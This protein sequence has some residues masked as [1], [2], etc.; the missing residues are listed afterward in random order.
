MRHPWCTVTALLAALAAPL[1]AGDPLPPALQGVEFAPVLNEQLPL[2]VPFHDESG[3]RVTLRDCCGGGKPVLLVLIQYRCPM[4][5]NLALNGLTESLRKLADER[6]FRLGEHFTVVG[7]SFDDRETPDVAAGKKASYL[8]AYGAPEAADAWRFL[9]G[10]KEAIHAVCDKAGFRFRYEKAG[11]RFAHDTGVLL[12]TPE[13]KIS[14]FFP[15]IEFAADDL[16]Y[17]LVEASEFRIGKP[18]DR[19]ALLFCYSYDPVRGTYQMTVVNAVRAA[20]V[21]TVVVLAG[22]V[23]MMLRRERRRAAG[24]AAPVAVSDVAMSEL[25]MS[26]TADENR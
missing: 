21:L 23:A 11:D 26:D 25:G 4:L 7:I 15:G 17:G 19:F 14:R 18:A 5:C 13:G 10:D 20:S 24:A 8:R 12:L 22:F 6:G 1:E 9:T 2:D 16:Y 3:Q